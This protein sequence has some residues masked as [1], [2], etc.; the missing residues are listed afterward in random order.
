MNAKN[1]R[2]Q[3]SISGEPEKDRAVYLPS[4]WYNG[5]VLRA[6]LERIKAAPKVKI[7]LSSV[8]TDALQLAGVK[9]LSADQ[10]AREMDKLG[11]P[12]N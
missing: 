7:T 5:V 3:A 11:A 6:T 1:V 2:E 10:L 12:R 4:G 9:E 8:I